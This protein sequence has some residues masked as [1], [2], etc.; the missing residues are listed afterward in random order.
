MLVILFRL[1]EPYKKKA[2]KLTEKPPTCP[3]K[4]IRK[5][6]LLKPKTYFMYHQL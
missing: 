3:Q 1:T 4:V 2:T 6:N 5:S